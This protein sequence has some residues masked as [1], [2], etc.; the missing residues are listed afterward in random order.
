MAQ[1]KHLQLKPMPKHL[2]FYTMQEYKKTYTRA[3][4][5]LNFL[6]LIKNF[7]KSSKKT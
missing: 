5:N 7:K 3:L 1:V 2:A 4:E 6:I